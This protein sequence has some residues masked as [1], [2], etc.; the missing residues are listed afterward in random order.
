[1]ITALLCESALLSGL[2]VRLRCLHFVVRVPEVLLTGTDWL[3]LLMVPNVH[4]AGFFVLFCII[5]SSLGVTLLLISLFLMFFSLDL[6]FFPLHYLF[7]TFFYFLH[8]FILYRCHYTSHL[9]V[10][11]VFFSSFGFLSLPF[12]IVLF[13]ICG[14]IL[15]EFRGTRQKPLTISPPLER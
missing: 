7:L 8:N 1:M 10:F 13:L 9:P 15:L 4:L 5:S 14:F 2:S 3:T 11:I 6:I 12:S